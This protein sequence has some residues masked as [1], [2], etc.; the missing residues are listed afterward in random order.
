MTG[1]AM[2]MMRLLSSDDLSRVTAAGR[3]LS[4]LGRQ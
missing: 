3:L 1:L 2:A 4:L